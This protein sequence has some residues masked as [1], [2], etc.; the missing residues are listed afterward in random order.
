V[1]VF[2]NPADPGVATADSVLRTT[3]LMTG[4]NVSGAIPATVVNSGL[5]AAM[6]GTSYNFVTGVG[7]TGMVSGITVGTPP[8][9]VGT[10]GGGQAFRGA[11]RGD[12]K[13]VRFSQITDGL[14]NSLFLGPRPF[15]GGTPPGTGYYGFW[16]N[17]Y[18]PISQFNLPL[19]L[20]APYIPYPAYSPT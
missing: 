4:V 18:S 13:A 10:K 3:W 5:P 6:G 17:S 12:N 1:L 2:E 14:S 19:N 8:N 9:E 15:S 16:A 11:F 7:G 20:P